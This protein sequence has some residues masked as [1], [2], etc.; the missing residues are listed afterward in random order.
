MA[1]AVVAAV[2]HLSLGGMPSAVQRPAGP[3]FAGLAGS[4][5]KSA[6]PSTAAS[7]G[8]GHAVCHCTACAEPPLP[9]HTVCI[10]A[11]PPHGTAERQ[12]A[13]IFRRASYP[14]APVDEPPALASGRPSPRR[15]RRS[16]A[17]AANGP[18]PPAQGL[19]LRA[20]TQ[21]RVAKSH[22]QERGKR[23]VWGPP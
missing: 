7:A 1:A 5:P 15:N 14:A 20:Y 16:T 19:S 11:S 2:G 18:R 12:Q 21:W 10:S 22:A 17:R 9:H 3:M 6:V 8:S 23:D 13:R 4:I